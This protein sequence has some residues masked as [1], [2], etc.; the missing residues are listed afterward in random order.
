M[1][2]FVMGNA[3]SSMHR[4]PGKVGDHIAPTSGLSAFVVIFHRRSQG[5]QHP[6]ERRVLLRVHRQGDCQLLRPGL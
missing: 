1:D 2:K 5:L 6:Q 4:A 3:I